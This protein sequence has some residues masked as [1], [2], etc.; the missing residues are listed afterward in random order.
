MMRLLTEE[1]A[2]E[3]WCPMARSI[4]SGPGALVAINRGLE[5]SA[6]PELCMC[7][8]SKCAMWEEVF[9]PKTR[10]RAGYCGLKGKA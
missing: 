3:T 1:E 4:A 8:A 2:K 9:D 5:V 7:I 6:L 10:R